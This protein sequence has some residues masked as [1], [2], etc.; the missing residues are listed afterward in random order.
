M[1]CLCETPASD[2]SLT[3]GI[4]VPLTKQEND[5]VLWLEDNIVTVDIET[6][7]RTIG[8]VRTIGLV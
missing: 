5:L 6:I 3:C 2:E 1:S 7:D 4:S 8:S